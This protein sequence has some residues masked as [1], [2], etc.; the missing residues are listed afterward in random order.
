MQKWEIKIDG[1]S[2]V[3]C[4][5]TIEAA[6]AKENIPIYYL[7]WQQGKGLI[8]TDD[9]AK[10]KRLLSA[11][12]YRLVDFRPSNHLPFV[13]IGSGSA[14]FAA[15]IE[16]RKQQTSVTLVSGPLFGGTCVNIGCIPSK[17]LIHNANKLPWRE[18][19]QKKQQLIEQLR[20]TKYEQVAKKWGISIVS[21]RCRFKDAHHLFIDDELFSF[22]TAIIATGAKPFTP[23]IA[24]LEQIA[25][26]HSTQALDAEKPPK[27]LCV[28]GGNAIGLELGQL[29]Q[30][31]QSQVYL[32][33]QQA[34]IAPFEEKEVSQF[35]TQQL[36]KEGM[37][38]YCSAQVRH[39]QKNGDNIKVVFTQ[40]G[41]DK[42]IEVEQ[43]LIATGVQ[44]NTKD[45]NLESA[46]IRTDT[47]GFIVVDEYLR[48]TNPKVYAAGDVTTYPKWVY[49]AAAMGRTAANNALNNNLMPFSFNTVAHVIFT[50]PPLASAGKYTYELPQAQAFVF[51]VADVPRSIITGEQGILKF[52]CSSDEKTILGVHLCMPHADSLIFAAQ[53]LVHC[54]VRLEEL[55]NTLIP[56]LTFAESFRLA[57]QSVD[58]PVD[59]LS[60]CA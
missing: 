32:I 59:A 48:T 46:G 17:F 22:D 2:C 26:W 51:D 15:A 38:I 11:H 57:A 19:Q 30:R 53:L 47:K 35:L 49:L 14:A 28:I 25:F 4:Q 56:Y 10:V 29:F 20:T 18:L 1:M 42:T 37:Q 34:T 50:D 7:N 41:S 24:G 23:N 43:L 13:V 52:V 21:G 16:A 44:G 12:S 54:G 55:Q 27:S 33:E 8:A 40:K 36:Q 3:G 6:L 60:C 39:V 5:H 31:V 9:I 45:L 58:V